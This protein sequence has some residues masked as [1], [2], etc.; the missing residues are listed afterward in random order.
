MMIY[1]MFMAAFFIV[2]L[3][4][5][6]IA[7]NTLKT[8]YLVVCVFSLFAGAVCLIL[9]AYNEPTLSDMLNYTERQAP[10]YQD[11]IDG[12]PSAMLAYCDNA[13]RYFG[14]CLARLEL[15]ATVTAQAGGDR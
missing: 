14:D 12:T 9:W 15:A 3:I 2:A 13:P 11:A 8:N 7:F 6:R 5:H 1:L 4:T 10:Y